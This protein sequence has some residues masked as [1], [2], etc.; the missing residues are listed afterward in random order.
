M[1]KCWKTLHGCVYSKASQLVTFHLCYSLCIAKSWNAAHIA[2]A[3]KMSEIL[4][5]R[6]TGWDRLK[7]G[8]VWCCD[9]LDK[10]FTSCSWLQSVTMKVCWSIPRCFMLAVSWSRC[11]GSS[12]VS[13]GNMSK[14][15][16]TEITKHLTTHPMPYHSHQSMT[17]YVRVCMWACVSECERREE[18]FSDVFILLMSVK[19]LV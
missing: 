4:A 9:F 2:R 16:L 10:L 13:P 5:L 14:S 18:M 6:S 12:D 19:G 1:T 17:W 15:A 3:S 8:K 7:M 11:C